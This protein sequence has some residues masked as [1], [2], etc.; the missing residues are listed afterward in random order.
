ML[1]DETFS[2]MTVNVPPSTSI[3]AR[4]NRGL[5]STYTPPTGSTG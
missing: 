3:S 1:S 4:S 5:P 2:A